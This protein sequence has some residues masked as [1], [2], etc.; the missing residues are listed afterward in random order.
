MKP[1][2]CESKGGSGDTNG[3]DGG[4]GGSG[5]TKGEEPPAPPKPPAAKPLRQNTRLKA[6]NRQVWKISRPLR[7]KKLTPPKSTPPTPE[8]IDF[9]PP[10]M[11]PSGGKGTEGCKCKPSLLDKILCALAE[12]DLDPHMN[13]I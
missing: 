12:L 3:E 13:Q 11:P 9:G 2:E 5:D 6:L 10:E 4:K 7:L 1:A 8:P